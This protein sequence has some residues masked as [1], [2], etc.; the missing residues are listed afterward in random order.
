MTSVA[1]EYQESIS[2][3][4]TR[5][6]RRNKELFELSKANFIGRLTV[7]TNFDSPIIRKAV[8]PTIYKDFAFKNHVRRK[9][10]PRRIYI[11]NCS[12]LLAISRL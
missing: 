9:R 6:S 1:V 12:Y 10:L 8:K 3:L 4:R 11:F 7:R 5:R 2:P